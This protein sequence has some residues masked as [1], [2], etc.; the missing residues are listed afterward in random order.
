MPLSRA[1]R[2]PAIFLLARQTRRT[3]RML[4]RPGALRPSLTLALLMHA[5]SSVL[6]AAP[7]TE[8]TAKPPS[9]PVETVSPS[10]PDF[11]PEPEER[12]SLHFQTTVA[13]QAH[14]AFDAAYSGQNSLRPE[15]E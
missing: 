15:A 1:A 10:A 7:A 14:P 3:G 11:T 4:M 9:T 12:L 13:V 5:F 2:R 6:H 8:G